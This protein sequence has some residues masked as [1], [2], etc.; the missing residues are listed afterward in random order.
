[1]GSMSLSAA[2][3]S[4]VLCSPPLPH[5]EDKFA[6]LSRPLWASGSPQA[7]GTSFLLHRHTKMKGHAATHST[8]PYPNQGYLTHT[9]RHTCI[10]HLL[11]STEWVLST[12]ATQEPKAGRNTASNTQPVRAP[13]CSGSQVPSCLPTSLWVI[14]RE[15]T[16]PRRP[17]WWGSTT[18][19]L[20]SNT[21]L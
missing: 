19:T 7:A 11:K 21:F 18:S 17:S 9:H 15:E 1:M 12:C 2:L 13:L 20:L 3:L 8:Q 14:T 5:P 4:L 16:M 6:T 10:Q